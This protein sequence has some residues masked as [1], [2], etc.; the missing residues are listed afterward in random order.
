MPAV[1]TDSGCPADGPTGGPTMQD[2]T[3][4]PAA[5]K[6]TATPAASS[7]VF[8]LDQAINAHSS[9]KPARTAKNTPDGNQSRQC[10]GAT[11]M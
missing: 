2:I 4:N 5:P 9:W 8:C 3:H 10:I 1:P 6:L 7:T 11:P